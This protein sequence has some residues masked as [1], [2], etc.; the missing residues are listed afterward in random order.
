MTADTTILLV[1]D[2]NDLADLYQHYL[3]TAY[4]VRLAQTG[5]EALDKATPTVDLIILD[6]KLPDISGIEVQEQ[7]RSDDLTIP[8]V[9]ISGTDPEVLRDGDKA[10]IWLVKPFYKEELQEAIEEVLTHN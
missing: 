4:E 9:M 3:D 2:N 8:T 6:Y 1:E 10:L 5:Q 7:L